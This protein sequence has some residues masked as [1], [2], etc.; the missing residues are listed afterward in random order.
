MKSLLKSMFYLLIILTAVSFAGCSSG[1]GSS[2]SPEETGLVDADVP[3]EVFA[4]VKGSV[5]DITW[6]G[7]KNDS[8]YTAAVTEEHE[9]DIK[10]AVKVVD[11]AKSPQSIAG[12]TPG[13]YYAWVIQVKSDGSN[14]KAVAA[15]GGAALVIED[16][17]SKPGDDG[18]GGSVVE[19]SEPSVTA[20]NPD[21]PENI[22]IQNPEPGKVVVVW[23][24]DANDGTYIVVIDD[25]N[26]LTDDETV[27]TQEGVSSPVIIDDLE[28]DDYYVWIIPVD[29][30]GN[31]GEPI[32]VNDG[33]ATE[34]FGGSLVA[35]SD[36]WDVYQGRSAII[37]AANLLDN[38]GNTVNEEPLEIIEVKD[39][40]NGTVSLSGAN[41]T[42]TSTGLAGEDAGFTYVARIKDNDLFHYEG[43]VAVNVNELPAVVAADHTKE[44][45]QGGELYLTPASFLEGAEGNGI[46]FVN[47]QNAVNGNLTVT[48]ETIT[49]K[50]TGLA[51]AVAQ[52]DYIIMDNLGTEAVGTVYITV[53][54]LPVLDA[55][56]FDNADLFEEQKVTYAPPTMQNVFNSWARF[57]GNNYYEN[58]D[59]SGISANAA[60]WELLEDP[61]RVSM[62]LNV[63][64][65]NGFL[66]P[67]HLENYT[68]EAT[69][70]SS[71]TTDNDNIGL[72]I[73]FVRIDGVNYSLTAM[74]TKGGMHPKSGWGVVYNIGEGASHDNYG[75]GGRIIEEKAVVSV[76]SGN[77]SG[78]KT[79][80]KIVRTGNI[81]KCYTTDWNDTENYVA[82]S[83]IVINLDSDL[84][85]KKFKGAMPYGYVS[86]SQPYSTYE[87]INIQGGL[88][89]STMSLINWGE[90]GTIEVWRYDEMQ[91]QW[92]I[93][94]SSTL[95]DVYGYVREVVNP[96]TGARYL[97]K[98]NS[99][100]VIEE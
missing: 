92:I 55:F 88:D 44:V 32:A 86:F 87:D 63:S 24:G 10:K 74:R 33:Q 39:A 30:E 11:I 9:F 68:F 6:Q 41:I 31:L 18:S 25:D 69:V 58:K 27:F 21:I 62:D 8:R 51:G 22:E 85:L 79:R 89:T 38:D 49:F 98:Q 59:A 3:S 56:I 2:D 60:A 99:V 70:T 42:F 14:G 82:A 40:V 5:I 35:A 15:N 29:A 16:T 81:V 13:R 4:E 84:D 71:Y 94:E 12:F 45:Q 72:V 100:E 61:Y 43:T 73:A 93:D 97:I 76:P 66:S 34:I 54:P 77:W 67:Q 90:G 65:Y 36:T 80:I 75:N 28:S 37:P 57:D 46:E 50:S 1:G 53:T 17:A 64:P 95:Q 26:D 23:D 83:E 48:S 47:A 78:D 7:N 19:D 52:F 96:V 91:S 20:V